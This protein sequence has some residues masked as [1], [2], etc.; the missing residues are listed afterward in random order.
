MIANYH[1][2]NFVQFD[3]RVFDVNLISPPAPSEEWD[4]D[5]PRVV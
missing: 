3:L 5:V 4:V 1:I 2:Q